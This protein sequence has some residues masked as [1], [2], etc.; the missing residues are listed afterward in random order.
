MI[1][2]TPTLIVIEDRTS[3]YEMCCELKLWSKFNSSII[4]IDL[5]HSRTIV[6]DDEKRTQSQDTMSI[7]PE[8]TQT[9][10]EIFGY[11]SSKDAPKNLILILDLALEFDSEVEKNI[12]KI[13]NFPSTGKL[14][15]PP[16]QAAALSIQHFRLL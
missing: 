8:D 5:S 9:Y 16:T 10:E 13:N 6:E 11:L 7:S 14:A 4:N 2:P 12:H 1:T 3:A 15:V